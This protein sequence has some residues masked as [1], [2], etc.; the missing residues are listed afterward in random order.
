M[1]SNEYIS[2]LF[3]NG[4]VV[5]TEQR[6]WR[7]VATFSSSVFCKKTLF[8]VLSMINMKLSIDVIV[9][10]M[11]AIGTYSLFKLVCYTIIYI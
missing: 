3:H 2:I 4:H 1:I 5:I 7:I 8:T 6:T 9:G 11:T 10:M